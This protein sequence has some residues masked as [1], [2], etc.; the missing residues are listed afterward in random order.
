MI[1]SITK[2]EEKIENAQQETAGSGIANKLRMFNAFQNK[3][4]SIT[5]GSANQK[6]IHFANINSYAILE[7]KLVTSDLAGFVKV[8]KL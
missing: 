1:S 8:W 2:E 7:N 6:N 4:Q 3:K 5:V